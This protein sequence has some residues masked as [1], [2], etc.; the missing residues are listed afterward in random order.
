MLFLKASSA[1][2]H[3]LGTTFEN[4]SNILHVLSQRDLRG[5]Q[6]V[7]FLSGATYVAPGQSRQLSLRSHFYERTRPAKIAQS[8]ADLRYV[9]SSTVRGQ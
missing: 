9:T 8:R 1:H 2:L 3:Q 7:S 6:F 4:S 5:T